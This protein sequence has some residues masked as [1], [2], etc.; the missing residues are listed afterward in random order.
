MAP[1]TLQTGGLFL[2]A[3]ALIKLIEFIINKY[4]KNGNGGK[5]NTEIALLKQSLKEIKENDLVHISRQLEENTNAHSLLITTINE[6]HINIARIMDK[7][8]I[9]N[10]TIRK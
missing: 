5:I 2:L 6:I 1:E 3:M 10:N 7:I 4:T 9:R 8:E